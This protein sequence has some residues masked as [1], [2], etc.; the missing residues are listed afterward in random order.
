MDEDITP[1]KAI[2]RG[3]IKSLDK[4][5]HGWLKRCQAIELAIGHTKSDNRM[6][7]CWLAGSMGDALHA[8][9]CAAW[10]NVRW[11]LRAI[12]AKGLMALLLAVSQWVLYAVNIAKILQVSLPAAG[13]RDR[14]LASIRSRTKP[15]LATA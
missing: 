11:L 3:K 10:F 5:Q 1:V 9:L 14:R 6:D 8:M 12:A 4:R 2:H 15:T 7:R 13:Q